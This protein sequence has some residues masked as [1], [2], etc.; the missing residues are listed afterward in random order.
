MST[1]RLNVG[2][3]STRL[4]GVDGVSL[5]TTKVA[6]AF[7]EMEHQV[8]Y[9]AGELETD[10]PPGMLVPEMHFAHETARRMHDQAFSGSMPD[11]V[12]THEIY[13][14]A[15]HL[16]GKIAGFV[17]QY[18]IDLLISQNA[19]CIPMN[20]AL[21]VAI[22]DYAARTHIPLIA[23]NHDFY[24]ER[25]RFLSNRV[26]DILNDAFPPKLSNARHWVISTI[27]QR[28]LK[29]WHGIDAAYLPNV[30][31]YANPPAPLDSYAM[32]VREV[33]GLDDDDLIVLQPTRVVR[34]KGIEKAIE[35]M[36][37]LD[38]PRLVLLLTGEG[39]DEPGGYAEWL[40]RLARQAGI[41]HRFIGEYVGSQRGTTEDGQPVFALW[42]LYPHAHIVT[43]PSVYE[44][45]GNA[46]LETLY[47]RK[48]LVVHTYP[49]YKANIRSVGVQAVE[50]S[51]DI[52]PQ[53]LQAV[54]RL[55]D[56]AAY[57]EA[58]VEANYRVAE[59]HFSYAVLRQLITDTLKSFGWG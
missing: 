42:D 22:R 11:P 21:G 34:R 25:E 2:M 36:E 10:G 24:W 29:A 16:R 39:S 20:L 55:I 5:E 17:E 14:M 19:S 33:L 58:M 8:F 31:D 32:R 49:V 15:D 43:Y 28:H 4:A 59:Q 3:L 18:S 37:R 57:R 51:H 30:F 46:L 44:G 26:Q 53:T 50:F 35:L 23:H 27:T 48:P 13:A 9:M 6:Q 38:D 41:R 47:F 1:R 12:L 45:F 54:Q 40:G 7:R 52:T 56:D